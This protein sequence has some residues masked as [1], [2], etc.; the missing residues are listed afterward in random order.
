MKFKKMYAFALA[1]TLFFV[2]S[3]LQTIALSSTSD[4]AEDEYVITKHLVDDTEAKIDLYP[5]FYT[6]SRLRD[7]DFDDVVIIPQE[8]TV[9]R[10]YVGKVNDKYGSYEDFKQRWLEQASPVFV[11]G[12]FSR[13]Y[14]NINGEFYSDRG[15]I[16]AIDGGITEDFL[17]IQKTEDR[18]VY[19]KYSYYSDPTVDEPDFFC[20]IKKIDGEWF[21]SYN[22]YHRLGAS[23][24]VNNDYDIERA[25]ASYVRQVLLSYAISEN[26][27]C[28]YAKYLLPDQSWN[29]TTVEERMGVYVLSFDV[30][31][32]VGSAYMFINELD[33][34][35]NAVGTKK[36]TVELFSE[37][38]NLLTVEDT[39][40]GDI[41][42]YDPASA[43]YHT[44]KL[45]FSDSEKIDV[46]ETYDELE[47]PETNEIPQSSMVINT[48]LSRLLLY[49]AP[50]VLILAG[51]G[52]F[53]Y[54][55]NRD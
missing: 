13:G 31:N 52:I 47:S 23:S 32:C 37:L 26:V 51:L 15:D 7:I 30:E 45:D 16:G 48:S 35:G 28:G 3:A 11:M 36:I 21:Q 6:G 39:Q 33:R 27:N 4:N 1:L 9:G 22:E 5:E 50:A 18:I 49:A 53:L 10:N 24:A 40:T 25:F 54:V 41:V 43:K 20:E 8:L 14:Y 38:R 2:V 55:R 34:D 19:G 29:S 17:I 12:V 44:V 42:Y 46:P